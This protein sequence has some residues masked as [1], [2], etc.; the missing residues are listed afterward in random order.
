MR[1][2]WPTAQKRRPSSAAANELATLILCGRK[3]CVCV[4]QSLTA[5][6][7][8]LLKGRSY[9]R[10]SS[11]RALLLREALVGREVEAVPSVLRVRTG[12]GREGMSR[13]GIGLT[14]SAVA[15]GETYASLTSFSKRSSPSSSTAAAVETLLFAFASLATAA[16]R[17][18]MR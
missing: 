5:A 3:L 10:E 9:A 1:E 14:V 13:S 2:S 12:A 18:A 15:H 16:F 4:V 11:S 8:R 7:S 6:F 17:A